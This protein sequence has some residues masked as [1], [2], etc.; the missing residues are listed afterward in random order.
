MLVE[1]YRNYR[2]IRCDRHE[3]IS[4][5]MRCCTSEDSHLYNHLPEALK[6]ETQNYLRVRSHILPQRSVVTV[7]SKLY[8]D[9]RNAQVFSL[10][11]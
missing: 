5:N 6:A 4:A 7:K 1:V 8:N 10:F 9:Q 2:G 3:A 11:I